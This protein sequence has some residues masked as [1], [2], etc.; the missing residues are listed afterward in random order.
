MCAI[1]LSKEMIRSSSHFF[2]TCA[3]N[4]QRLLHGFLVASIRDSNAHCIIYD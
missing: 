1:L 3:A 2:I 4:E